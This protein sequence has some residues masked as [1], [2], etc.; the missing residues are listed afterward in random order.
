[1]KFNHLIGLLVAFAI[2]VP[3]VSASSIGSENS[4]A[5][6]LMQ[7]NESV[8]RAGYTITQGETDYH[9]YY[10]S[11][12]TSSFSVDLNWFTDDHSLKLG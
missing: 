1:M 9:G 11:P 3:M 6:D 7:K 2:V 4:E 8:A 12:G 10:V 5:V